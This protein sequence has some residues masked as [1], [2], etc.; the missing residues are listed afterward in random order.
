MAAEAEDGVRYVKTKPDQVKRSE[1]DF[2]RCPK[3]HRLPHRSRTGECTP[4]YC[5][6]P[7]AEVREKQ[8]GKI[9]KAKEKHLPK[10]VEEEDQL[11]RQLLPTSGPTGQL[12]REAAVIS[13]AE[14]VSR[15]GRGAGRFAARIGALGVPL[16]LK[17]VAAEQWSDAK[18]IELLPFAVAEKEYQL[19]F[20]DD[21]MRER[22]A[23]AVLSATGRK[24]KD[25]GGNSA[26]TIIV[27]GSGSGG[28]LNYPW[29]KRA[30]PAK[31][32][33]PT[34]AEE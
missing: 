11:I 16:G 32:P 14:E 25:G 28:Q 6:E 7:E 23:D 31:L 1:N 29:A 8:Q 27:V 5:A 15:L 18:L 21:A 33:E 13:K 3:N 4:L 9:E 12:S 30:Q 34:D 17:D 22:A 10:M 24:Q 26:P 20:G 2:L 19:K